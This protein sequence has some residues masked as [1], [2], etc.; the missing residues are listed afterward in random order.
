MAVFY[1]ISDSTSSSSSSSNTS[2]SSFSSL[3]TDYYS[4]TNGSYKKLVKAYYAKNNADTSTNTDK[5]ELTTTKSSGEQLAQAAQALTKTGKQS[6]FEKI[7]VTDENTGITSKQYDVD[8][9][10]K[11]V[12]SLVES[13]N[14]VLDSAG[15]STNTS[16]LRKT[17]SM[18]NQVKVYS[19]AL[20]DIGITV[21]ADNKLSLNEDTFKAADM[22]DVK[23][24]FQGSV[25]VGGKFESFGR[26]IANLSNCAINGVNSIYTSSGT[27]AALTTGNLYDSLF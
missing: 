3:L 11:N 15:D 1:G 17:V 24:L 25:S 8:N 7:D 5:L 19:S 22:A 4:I 16:V 26:D 9:I 2:N 23:A 6:V 14:Q 20:N 12:K 21:G 27:Y 18:I 13:Y 10:F